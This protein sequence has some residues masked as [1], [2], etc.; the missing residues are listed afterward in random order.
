MSLYLCIYMYDCEIHGL[1]M[2]CYSDFNAFRYNLL[3]LCSSQ[4]PLIKLN[5]LVNHSDCNGDWTPN[6]CKKLIQELNQAKEIIYKIFYEDLEEIKETINNI[7]YLCH[8]S[9]RYNSSIIFQ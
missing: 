2:G 4:N 7:L 5:T 9:V 1:D 6:Q 3:N 8:L